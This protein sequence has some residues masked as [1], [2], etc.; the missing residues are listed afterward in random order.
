MLACTALSLLVVLG[1]MKLWPSPS[2]DGRNDGL[3][4][5]AAREVIELETVQPTAQERRPPPPPRPLLPVVVPD[6]AELDDV[7]LQLAE[8]V[9]MDAPPSEPGDDLTASAGAA[10]AASTRVVEEAPKALRFVVPEYTRGARERGI[11]A[12]V[13]IEVQVDERG[14]VK[15]ARIMERVLLD[16]EG[17]TIRRVEELGYGLDQ[18]VL[19]AARRWLFRPARRN[20]EPVASVTTIQLDVGDPRSNS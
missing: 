9:P 3:F 5:T 11:Q 16:E 10:E 1:A 19:S 12:T 15:E 7:E 8:I 17:A 14:R 20:G 2:S 18:A 4:A 13:Q 6:A